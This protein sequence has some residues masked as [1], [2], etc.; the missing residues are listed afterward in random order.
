MTQYYHAPTGRVIN[1]LLSEFGSDVANYP[2]VRLAE[3]EIYSIVASSVNYFNE[4]GY[5]QKGY[6]YILRSN[7]DTFVT[8]IAIVDKLTTEDTKGRI[9][10]KIKQDLENDMSMVIKAFGSSKAMLAVAKDSNDRTPEETDFIEKLNDLDLTAKNTI[11]LVNDVNAEFSKYSEKIRENLI[12]SILDRQLSYEGALD[13][14]L[15]KTY[16]RYGLK[17][18]FPLSGVPFNDVDNI[19]A[20]ISSESEMQAPAVDLS[21]I[22][23]FAIER[24]WVYAGLII[25]DVDLKIDIDTTEV[26]D[27]NSSNHSDESLNIIGFSNDHS[28]LFKHL[29]I[30]EMDINEVD[31]MNGNV[32]GVF[33]VDGNIINDEYTIDILDNQNS[34]GGTIT[35]NE[36]SP[37][38][39]VGY[40]Q[41]S[42][43]VTYS[44]KVL[45]YDPF[46]IATRF[47]IIGEDIASDQ[48]VQ[49]LTPVFPEPVEIPNMFMTSWFDQEH[50][51]SSSGQVIAQDNPSGF[52]LLIDDPLK[53]NIIQDEINNTAV[54]VLDN[55]N[56]AQLQ[57]TAAGSILKSDWS[58]E[59]WFYISSA[60][61]TTGYVSIAS[62]TD[63]G[64]IEQGLRFNM[65][66]N[67]LYF[68]RGIGGGTTGIEFIEANSTIL[69]RDTWFSVRINHA[70]DV[71]SSDAAIVQVYVNDSNA[72]SIPP[73]QIR[74]AWKKFTIG[75]LDDPSVGG[76]I[77]RIGPQR[78]RSGTDSEPTPVIF[79]EYFISEIPV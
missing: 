74:T 6:S 40:L 25:R 24:D 11:A 60:D 18:G 54:Y 42:N 32:K 31:W 53:Y 64:G 56:K 71:F 51:T 77:G 49:Q 55:A 38:I 59:G 75:T 21:D 10:N 66:D 2:P 48:P 22:V 68:A 12:Q 16:L 46:E 34:Y 70:L 47:V 35:F 52:Y 5:S 37:I 45:E 29:T 15:L 63:S 4:Y 67:K 7:K 61:T 19:V 1:D 57:M 33:S 27:W 41:D 58:H 26:D 14:N 43:P 20:R 39:S 30:N 9:I 72:D 79:P 36:S 65:D 44:L 69:P 3:L 13:A 8:R 62:F 78:I 76:W 50:S 73:L 23:N 28:Y 17:V